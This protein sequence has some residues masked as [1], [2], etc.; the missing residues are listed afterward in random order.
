MDYESFLARV[1]EE[2]DFLDAFDVGSDEQ[3]L[4]GAAALVQLR[5]Y[6][7]YMIEKEKSLAAALAEQED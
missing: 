7:P 1:E 4:L 6:I 5:S 2:L 3:L